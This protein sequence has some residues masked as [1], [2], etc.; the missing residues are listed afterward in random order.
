MLK[1]HSEKAK[2]KAIVATDKNSRESTSLDQQTK[3]IESE[4]DG[5]LLSGLYIGRAIIHHNAENYK[6]AL[7]DYTS[8]LNYVEESNEIIH[9]KSKISSILLE[10]LDT[11]E[12]RAFRIALEALNEDPENPEAICAF[13]KNCNR[14][15]YFQ[16]G[17][18][19]IPKKQLRLRPIFGQRI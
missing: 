16:L 13:G 17:D 18:I 2:G 9:I 6:E 19:F 3:L 5:H 11:G 4:A 12:E 8:A 14:R 15:E 7:N 10:N 1:K